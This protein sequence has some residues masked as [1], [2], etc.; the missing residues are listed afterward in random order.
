MILQILV[1]LSEMWNRYRAA[2]LPPQQTQLLQQQQKPDKDTTEEKAAE[3]ITSQ[4][5]NGLDVRKR[6]IKVRATNAFI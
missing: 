6:N 5:N 2:P 1:G 4:K 3:E